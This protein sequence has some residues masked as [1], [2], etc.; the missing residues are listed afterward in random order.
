MAIVDQMREVACALLQAT[1]DLEAHTLHRQAVMPCCPKAA[2]K[3]VHTR[4]VQPTTLC[5][6]M[7]ITVR[8]FPM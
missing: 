5:G 3:Y 8:T 2:L 1:V 7:R 6:P 4:T